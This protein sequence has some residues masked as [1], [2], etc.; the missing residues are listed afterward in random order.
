MYV[1]SVCIIC[2]FMS[3]F[4]KDQRTVFVFLDVKLQTIV[5]H[6]VYAG[7]WT[8]IICE[9]SYT[10]ELSLQPWLVSLLPVKQAHFAIIF[11]DYF[12]NAMIVYCSTK[13]ELN[14]M[15]EITHA[16]IPFEDETEK[17]NNKIYIVYEIILD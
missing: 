4:R 13:L 8:Q 14:T 17:K 11:Y 9:N 2:A 5:H 10:T 7:T 3:G 15:L 12:L 16:L 6:H 1:L